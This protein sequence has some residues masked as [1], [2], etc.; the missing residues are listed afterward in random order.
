MAIVLDYSQGNRSPYTDPLARGMM[1]GLTL[2]HT[3]GHVFRA[4]IE[5]ICYGMRTSCVP[6]AGRTSSRGST[7]SPL[8]RQKRA[9]DA[10][11]RRCLGCPISLPTV[12]D[13]PAL[14]SAMLAAVWGGYLPRYSN[15]AER[16]WFTPR[17]PSSQTR[18][19]MKVHVLRGPLP[20]DLPP[21]ERA[22]HKT[23]RHVAGGET[24]VVRTRA[25]RT[26]DS[27]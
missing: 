22:M 13:G 24:A 10:D 27:L 19:A 6:C 12:S 1:W 7:S 5:G 8:V 14:G 16:R 25:I 11:A 21:D 20:G 26:G 2:S 3:P 15:R 18:N 4:I 23:E 17:T 9:V